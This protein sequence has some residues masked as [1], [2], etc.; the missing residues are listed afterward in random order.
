MDKKWMSRL[1]TRWAT[2]AIVAALLWGTGIRLGQYLGDRSLW[3]DEA[4]LAL[5]VLER[6]FGQLLAPLRG[7]QGAPILF[8]FVVKALT[9]LLGSSDWV[10]RLFPFAT[11]IATLWIFWLLARRAL[12]P[13]YALIGVLLLVMS[14]RQAWYSQEFKQ[15]AVDVA[16]A[17][18]L[19]LSAAALGNRNNPGGGRFASLAVLGGISVW[20]SH[21]SVFVMA[22]IG[23]GLAAVLLPSGRRRNVAG[24]A[25]V[26]AVWLGSFAA[27]YA[28][29]IGKLLL[30]GGLRNYWR[31]EYLP[32]PDSF[33]H[34]V[35][36]RESLIG[37]L[38]WCHFPWSAGLL[39]L[40]LG[41]LGVAL[42]W[43]T[44]RLLAIA[45]PA[46]YLAASL[47][48][49]AGKY[50]LGDRLALFLLPAIL[51]LASA[52][53]QQVCEGRPV[54]VYLLLAALLVGPYAEINWPLLVRPM[55]REEIKPLLAYL[56]KNAEAGDRLQ[57]HV[58]GG[59]PLHRYLYSKEFDLSRLAVAI[60]S[61]GD[62]DQNVGLNPDDLPVGRVWL[63]FSHV[64]ESR[65]ERI[66][67][68]VKSQGSLL[69]VRTEPG[70]FLYLV[71]FGARESP[72]P[73]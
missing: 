6:D 40:A 46:T 17:V 38:T 30:H 15:Y 36:W 72:D 20:L 9:L 12:K 42:L 68:Y 67:A 54:A 55:K 60:G 58:D 69:D 16:V 61:R 59:M 39:L 64:E 31:K 62:D 10:L 41:A 63:L 22:G 71:D 14:G 53:V 27:F 29:S 1:R 65:V 2:L 70:A 8:L 37:F 45:L 7:A 23:L 43:R 21:P 28:V 47:A 32:P 18:A 5:N 13:P 11:G 66:M 33:A 4:M 48:S 51:L 3:T 24:L 49:M 57:V 25:G 73:S 35:A 19:F 34:L 50:P 44:N 56:T 52:G 26:A